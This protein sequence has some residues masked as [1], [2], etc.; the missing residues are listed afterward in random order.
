MRWLQDSKRQVIRRLI[1]AA[2]RNGQHRSLRRAVGDING[3]NIDGRR[4]RAHWKTGVEGRRVNAIGRVIPN[5]R[6][7]DAGG[8]GGIPAAGLAENA[9]RIAVDDL[10]GDA[11]PPAFI[12]E[13]T[14]VVGNLV[15]CLG[16]RAVQLDDLR[17]FRE[18]TSGDGR[19]KD[20]GRTEDLCKY[21]GRD[22]REQERN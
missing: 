22:V 9:A 2:V 13:P 12:C 15:I 17:N 7:I 21:G 18:H 20:D 5:A 4:T 16:R 3:C 8:H 6:N 1:A 10:R 14:G 19:I 11:K